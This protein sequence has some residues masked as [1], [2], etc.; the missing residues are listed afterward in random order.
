M[1]KSLDPIKDQISLALSRLTDFMV[2]WASLILM[3]WAGCLW[4][5]YQV[6]TLNY[7]ERVGLAA[8]TGSDVQ[9]WLVARLC[10]ALSF[11]IMVIVFLVA[12]LWWRRAGE[13]HLR[14]SQLLDERR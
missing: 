10:V 11:T 6:R 14:G 4:F 12:A 9:C 1:S 2:G 3:M 13:K 5:P 8:W 7:L